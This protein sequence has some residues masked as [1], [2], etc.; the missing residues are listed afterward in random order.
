MKTSSQHH[1]NSKENSQTGATIPLE[2]SK[3]NLTPGSCFLLSDEGV[4][5][6]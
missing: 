1:S 2:G 6:L 5:Y 3:R 4:Y